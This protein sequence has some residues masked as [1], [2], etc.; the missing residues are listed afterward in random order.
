MSM[1]AVVEAR[2]LCKEFGPVRALDDV[3]FTIEGPGLTTILG[4]NG[5]GKTTLLDVLEGLSDASSGDYRLFGREPRPYPRARVGVVMQREARL[6]RC[7]VREYAELFGAIYGIDDGA[8]RILDRS[9]L[10]HRAGVAVAALSGGESARLFLATA[11]VHDPELLFLDEP[12]A[13]LDPTSKREVG[14][15]LRD[16]AHSRTVVMTTHDLREADELSDRLLFLVAGRV[17]ASGTREELVSA[18]PTESRRGIG[19]EGAFFHFCS[20]TIRDGERAER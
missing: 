12:T 17:R 1:G 11:S 20:C 19:V 10:S 6:D 8:R 14:T 3:S 7:T 5:A 15:L 13:P 16:L 9:D 2:G 4:P 18:V